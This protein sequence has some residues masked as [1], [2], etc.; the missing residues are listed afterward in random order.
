MEDPGTDFGR[1]TYTPT[2]VDYGGGGE[3]ISDA[4]AQRVFQS[5]PDLKKAAE[6]AKKEAA[7]AERQKKR[8]K[9]Q[10]RIKKEAKKKKEKF[11]YKKWY[12]A[13]TKKAIN[14]SALDMY[15][16]IEQYVDPMDDY[17]LTAAEIAD[18]V[19]K[20]SSYGYNF[21]GP[22]S[23][24]EDSVLQNAIPVGK[25]YLTSNKGTSIESERK[26]PYTVNPTTSYGLLNSLLNSTRKDTRVTAQNTL[27]AARKYVAGATPK[28]LGGEGWTHK[29][30]T[31]YRDRNKP[32]QSGGGGDGGGYM[33]YP[34][35]A[36]WKAAQ[37][38]GGTTEV[39]EVVEDTPSEFQSSIGSTYCSILPYISKADL[40]I[41]FF[42]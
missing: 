19:A 24:Y 21:S 32:P 17:G 22:K 1:D 18:L 39:T 35:Y 5:R 26:N 4:Q 12:D 14:K 15:G 6:D 31:D 33:G 30:Y 2:D 9:T 40:F 20:D 25:K 41:A 11:S 42:V 36:A 10:K 16:R 7:A 34:S 3:Q 28:E 27:D 37:G 23:Y 29:E 13:Q 38:Q 8:K